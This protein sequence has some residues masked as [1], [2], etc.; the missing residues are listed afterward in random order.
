MVGR[1]RREAFQQRRGDTHR[2]RPIRDGLSAFHALAIRRARTV[3]EHARRFAFPIRVDRAM[4]QAGRRAH[5]RRRAR[6]DIRHHH[7]RAEDI[8]FASS[9]KSTDI[10]VMA[11]RVH[12]QCRAPPASSPKYS[13]AGPNS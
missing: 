9:V 11:F 3:F 12:R 4:Q 13:P 7:V 2:R 10:Q 8:D 1:I 6:F 5:Q